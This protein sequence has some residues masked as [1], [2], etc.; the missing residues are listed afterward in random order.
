MSPEFWSE[1][2]KEVSC[3]LLQMGTSR[4]VCGLGHFF[5]AWETLLHIFRLI[6]KIIQRRGE[7][8]SEKL[9]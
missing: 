1:E 4:W 6:G 5:K 3:H 8:D 9:G 2:P 7:N